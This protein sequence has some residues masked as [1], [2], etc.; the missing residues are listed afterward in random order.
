MLQSFATIICHLHHH[1]GKGPL[2]IFYH[3]SHYLY[4]FYF[5]QVMFYVQNL[6]CIR[7]TPKEKQMM[8]NCTSKCKWSTMWTVE[9]PPSHGWIKSLYL[10]MQMM[11]NCTS[12]CNWSTM[13]I[14][15][16]LLIFFLSMNLQ[17]DHVWNSC[18]NEKIYLFA[19]LGF[20]VR[21]WYTQL[22]GIFSYLNYHMRICLL[23]FWRLLGY[24]Y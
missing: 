14:I 2:H 18:V 21:A 5:S 4:F 6:H 13:W 17:E 3:C 12:K 16:P 23:N 15:D 10:Q 9:P 24:D 11:C 7:S 20:I 22:D 1:V 8:C 19:R